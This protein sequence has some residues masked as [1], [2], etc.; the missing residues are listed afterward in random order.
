MFCIFWRHY[1]D[2]NIVLCSVDLFILSNKCPVV[3]FC[4]IHCS[5]YTTS[6]TKGGE[7]NQACYKLDIIVNNLLT[8]LFVIY[9]LQLPASSELT[10]IFN[11]HFHIRSGGG[12]RGIYRGKSLFKWLEKW[13]FF[14]FSFCLPLSHGTYAP[15]WAVTN[16]SDPWPGCA[17]TP[18]PPSVMWWMSTPS[19]WPPVEVRSV[20]RNCL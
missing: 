11:L 13:H 14:S 19:E 9:A 18:P 3:F 17:A 4:D 20:C 5:W 16:R 1:L 6:N 2:S 7:G 8:A 10:S 15:C 12:E